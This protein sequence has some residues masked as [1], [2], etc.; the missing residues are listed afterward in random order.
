MKKALVL[1]GGSLRCMFSAGAVDVLMEHGLKFEGVFGA[2][3]GAMTGLNYVAGQI[4]RTAK[5]NIDFAR[6]SRY[7]GV[8]PLLAHRSVFN[9][10]F[11]FNEISNIYIPLDR[12]AFEASS[13]AFTAVVTSVRTGEPIYFNKENCGDIYRAVR[14][15]S[16]MPLLAPIVT[17][18]GEPCLDGGISVAIPYQKA[19]DEGY[20]KILVLPTREHGFRKPFTPGSLA[21]MYARTYREHPAFIRRLIDTP[22]MYDREMNEIDRLQNAGAIHV[23]RPEKP[24]TISRTEKD[25]KKLKALYEEGRRVCQKNLSTILEYLEV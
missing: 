5:V 9:F 22:R 6:D 15:S 11:L 4:G 3:A 25:P 1:E 24:I 7:Y 8:R 14:A 2:S 16:S 10:D 13:C 18:D 12:K 17:V 21:R 23:L 20:D 19:L